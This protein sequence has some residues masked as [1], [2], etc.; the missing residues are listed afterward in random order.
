MSGLRRATTFAFEI[1]ENI[2][3]H[4]HIFCRQKY[5][6]WKM[7][8]GTLRPYRILECVH[9]ELCW[10]EHESF[11]ASFQNI[12]VSIVVTSRGIFYMHCTVFLQNHLCW[13]IPIVSHPTLVLLKLTTSIYCLEWLHEITAICSL[14]FK[15]TVLSNCCHYA[16]CVSFK[17][18]Y[19][20]QLF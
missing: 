5:F 14:F 8:P 11:L 16:G 6:S 3:I 1:H 7:G 18:L 15:S 12:V 13:E 20:Y 17:I 10:S 4:F 9:V 2:H 19:L